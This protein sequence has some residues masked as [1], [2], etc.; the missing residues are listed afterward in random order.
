MTEI[1]YKELQSKLKEYR[2][3]GYSVPALNSTKQILL[4]AYCEIINNQS[5][6][7]LEQESQ[8]KLIENTAYNLFGDLLFEFGSYHLFD[9]MM[10]FSEC[11]VLAIQ[12]RL[13]CDFDKVRNYLF[14][15]SY[16][17]DELK[18]NYLPIYSQTIEKQFK[19]LAITYL[20]DTCEVNK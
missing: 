15:V 4:D 12:H 2:N 18:E 13:T 9:T 3:K 14:R 10:K 5:T 8:K 20:Q 17:Y 19:H 16:Y 1:S 6:Q 7:T 11:F